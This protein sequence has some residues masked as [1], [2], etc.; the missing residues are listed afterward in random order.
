MTEESPAAGNRREPP[1]VPD[2][3]DDQQLPGFNG[4]P[5]ADVTPDQKEPG[6]PKNFGEFML[7]LRF[8]FGTKMLGI[9]ILLIVVISLVGYFNPRDS[10]LLNSAL[11]T[12]KLVATTL[13]G[14][15]F[16]SGSLGLHKDGDGKE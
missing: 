1:T 12:L 6:K 8:N 7:Q 10:Q 2:N 14:Y 3:S 13:M 9:C 16:G 5:A 11:E 15:L 4:A